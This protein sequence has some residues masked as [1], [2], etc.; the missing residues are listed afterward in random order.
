MV[1]ER[2]LIQQHLANERTYL[3]WIRTSVALVGVGFLATTV[4][5]SALPQEG[6]LADALAMLVSISSLFLGLMTIIGA[7]VNYYHTR[8][9]INENRFVSSHRIIVYMTS[10]AFL[11]F[12]LVTVYLMFI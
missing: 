10:V 3:A 9:N 8:R 12:L 1:D 11:L 4:H 2:K 5:F 7:T 6:Q